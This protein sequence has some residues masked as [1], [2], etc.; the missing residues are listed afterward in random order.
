MQRGETQPCRGTGRDAQP[1]AEAP[2]AAPAPP[3]GALPWTCAAARARLRESSA[4]GCRAW[5]RCSCSSASFR[6]SAAS[7]VHWSYPS[8]CHLT[9]YCTPPPFFLLPDCWLATILSTCTP[10]GGPHLSAPTSPTSA[11]CLPACYLL[12]ALHLLSGNAV[13]CQARCRAEELAAPP[14]QS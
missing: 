7:Q 11:H 6:S 9:R 3:A 12:A 14:Q 4:M 2:G 5:K 13:Q 8:S 10:G 1:R